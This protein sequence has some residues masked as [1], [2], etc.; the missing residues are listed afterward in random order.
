MRIILQPLQ[1]LIMQLNR[2]LI[3]ALKH[4]CAF[5]V[6]QLQNSVSE[7][8]EFCWLLHKNPTQEEKV[9]EC[10]FP[11][12]YYCSEYVNKS[13]VISYIWFKCSL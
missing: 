6:I 11:S 7:V 3:K 4:R 2:K 13:A 10:G 8:L 1:S 5:L 12:P 9:R